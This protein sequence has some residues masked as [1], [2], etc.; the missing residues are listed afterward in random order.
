MDFGSTIEVQP[1]S[2]PPRCILIPD[3]QGVLTA[4][5]VNSSK[6]RVMKFRRGQDRGHRHLE[7]CGVTFCLCSPV[8]VFEVAHPLLWGRGGGVK[9]RAISQMPPRCRETVLL[10]RT[11]KAFDCYQQKHINES[12]FVKK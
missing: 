1:T 8:P 7:P 6:T 4:L 9:R 11:H 12:P 2:Y 3:T 10:I 5:F